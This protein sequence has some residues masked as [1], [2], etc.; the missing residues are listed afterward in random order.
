MGRLKISIE[1]KVKLYEQAKLFL[2]EHGISISTITIDCKITI[3]GKTSVPINL[4][5]L[6]LYVSLSEGKIEQINYGNP[7]NI[8]TNRSIIHF[9]KKKKKKRRFYNQATVLIRPHNDPERNYVN[10]KIFK[11]GALHMTGCKDISDCQYIAYIIIDSLK[12][13]NNIHKD[14]S[15]IKHIKFIDEEDSQLQ[16]SDVKIRMIN[17]NFKVNYKIDRK[18]LYSI[19]KIRHKLS[20]KD[21][22]IGYVDCKYDPQGGHS[23]VN[24]KYNDNGHKTSIFIFQTGSIIITG[25]KA[26]IQI[27][28]AYQFIMKILG[29]YYDEI[30]VPDI[31]PKTVSM[32]ISKYL[33]K[34]RSL[35]LKTES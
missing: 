14:D 27:I 33:N 13:G 5:K 12:K 18:K 15:G 10:V 8:Y 30:K 16:I 23:C 3:D 26:L 34:K 11:N 21:K 22:E 20:T 32:E 19:L 24:I 28:S 31:D 4:N 29:K 25:A 35:Q 2:K 9:I 1:N 6:A 7:K 17:S